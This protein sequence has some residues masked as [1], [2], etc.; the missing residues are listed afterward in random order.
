M[1]NELSKAQKGVDLRLVNIHP[2]LME[3]TVST[4]QSMD[5]IGKASRVEKSI[6]N[7]VT[8]LIAE[9]SCFLA[10]ASMDICF[11]SRHA[12]KPALKSRYVERCGDKIS[13]TES[14]FRDDI[15]NAV[16]DVRQDEEVSEDTSADL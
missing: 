5:L 16:K 10:G 11:A 2:S 1:W 12:I 4:V 15:L 7:D 3:A 9:T 6:R 13:I 14:L 8:Q